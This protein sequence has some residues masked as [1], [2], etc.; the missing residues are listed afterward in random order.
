MRVMLRMLTA[1]QGLIGTKCQ[2]LATQFYAFSKR[3]G[4]IP[5]PKS[6]YRS[7]GFLTTFRNLT[8]LRGL[9]LLSGGRTLSCSLLSDYDLQASGVVVTQIL[10]LIDQGFWS[11]SVI[12]RS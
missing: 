5:S 12:L 10:W 4:S 8:A 2:S 6:T 1:I 7:R 11:F 3:T 9:Q